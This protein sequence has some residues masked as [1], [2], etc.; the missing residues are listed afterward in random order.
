MAKPI[1]QMWQKNTL[2]HRLCLQFGPGQS[3]GFKCSLNIYYAIQRNFHIPNNRSQLLLLWIDTTSHHTRKQACMHTAPSVSLFIFK[4]LCVVIFSIGVHQMSKYECA[5]RFLCSI[6]CACVIQLQTN[7]SDRHRMEFVWYF[8][9]VM[10]FNSTLF[11]RATHNIKSISV[12]SAV[13][14]ERNGLRKRRRKNPPGK[15]YRIAHA[16]VHM[17]KFSFLV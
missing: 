10:P 8:C 9:H 4:V 15:L 12:D 13:L 17:R 7:R 16:S 3:Q 6:A 11:N 5:N 14:I 2:F 1:M